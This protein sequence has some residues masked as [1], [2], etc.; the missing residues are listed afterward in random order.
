MDGSIAFALMFK[1]VPHEFDHQIHH[2]TLRELEE[3]I[4]AKA[5]GHEKHND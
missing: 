5:L 1:A 2:F 3:Y 4:S